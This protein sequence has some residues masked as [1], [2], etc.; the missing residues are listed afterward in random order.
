MNDEPG[1]KAKKWFIAITRYPRRGEGT[2]MEA[3]RE[4]MH[5]QAEISQVG[6]LCAE[7]AQHLK[8]KHED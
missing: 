5:I 4:H 6:A 7:A 8:I 3:Q 2:K 1:N